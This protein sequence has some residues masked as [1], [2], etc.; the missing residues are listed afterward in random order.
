MSAALSNDWVT[1]GVS[2]ALGAMCMTTWFIFSTQGIFFLWRARAQLNQALP[3]F[4]QSPSWDAACARLKAIDRCGLLSSLLYEQA[5]DLALNTLDG[6]TPP[7][8]RRT[9]HLREG[10]ALIHHKLHWGQNVLATIGATAP[11]IGLLGTVWGI[12]HALGTLALSSTLSSQLSIDKIASPVGEALIMTAAGL[13]VALP[14]VMIYNLM[15]RFSVALE[16]RYEGFAYD[17]QV[18]SSA[19]CTLDQAANIRTT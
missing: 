4:W 1:Q 6:Q 2:W 19:W 3:V 7:E 17:L 11:F 13:F 10:L 14:A 16:A 8:H 18:C 12:Y 5:S 15:N 9:R